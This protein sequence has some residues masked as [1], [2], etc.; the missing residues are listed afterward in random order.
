MVK[1]LIV[2]DEPGMRLSLEQ[3]LEDLLVKGVELLTAC[4]GE[5]AIEN[6]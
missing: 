1:I 4:N 3:T 6:P 2:D 5:E